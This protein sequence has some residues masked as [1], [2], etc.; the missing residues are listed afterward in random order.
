LSIK[1]LTFQK[2]IKLRR[3]TTSISH[4]W[5][6]VVIPSVLFRIFLFFIWYSYFKIW[7]FW[8]IDHIFELKIG[9]VICFK[10]CGIW[11]QDKKRL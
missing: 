8:S 5:I 9:D 3:W 4:P 6:F 7:R 11:S 1:S 2:K 10:W